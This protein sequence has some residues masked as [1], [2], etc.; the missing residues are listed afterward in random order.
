MAEFISII[1]SNIYYTMIAVSLIIV[2]LFLV[3]KKLLKLF[4]YAAVI[5][6]AFLAYIYYTGKTVDSVVRPVEKAIEKAEK[7]VK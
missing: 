5:L 6:I 2:I 7:L 3:I 4:I 1:L